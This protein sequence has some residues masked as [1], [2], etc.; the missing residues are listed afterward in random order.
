MGAMEAKIRQK[1]AVPMERQA[2]LHHQELRRRMHHKVCH[3][4]GNPGAVLGKP[5]RESFQMF[6]EA[7]RFRRGAPH[8]EAEAA[9]WHQG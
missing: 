4:A 5:P 1:Q 6:P 2:E 9:H 3:L 7:P 8:L